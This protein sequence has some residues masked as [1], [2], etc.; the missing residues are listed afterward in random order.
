MQ[1]KYS[2][3]KYQSRVL[4]E[5]NA[6][7]DDNHLHIVAAPGS[8]KTILGLEVVKRL[9]KPTLILAPTITIRNQWIDRLTSFF[10]NFSNNKKPDW[11]SSDI[12]HP[13]IFIVTTYQALHSALNHTNK[14]SDHESNQKKHIEVK[15]SHKSS[16]RTYDS[17]ILTILKNLSINT[18]VLDE[19]HHLRT[20]WWKS[21]K[22]LIRKL[23]HPRTIALTAT[24]PYDVPP[25]EF[26]RYENLCGPIDS[27]ISVPELVL[28]K[29][30]CPHQDYIYFCTPS[31]DERL[32]I[33]SFRDSIKEFSNNLLRNKD[34]ISLI[35]GQKWIQNTENYIDEI[36]TDPAFFSSTIIFLKEAGYTVPNTILEVLGT[37][38]KQIPYFSLEWLEIFLNGCLYSHF[39][40]FPKEN[41]LLNEVKRNLKSIG[42]IYR[43]KIHLRSPRKIVKLL[44]TSKEKL[45]VIQKIVTQENRNM[46]HR[47]RL[48]ILTDYIKKDEF[49]HSSENNPPL[50][51]LGVVPIFEQIR[52]ENSLGIKI[53]VLCGTLVII[54]LSSLSSF[55]SIMDKMGIDSH[56]FN[57]VEL[58][59]DKNYLEVKLVGSFRK[60]IVSIITELFSKGDIEVLVGTASL[61][62][63]GWDAP[64]INTL[65]LASSVGSY[66]LS[67]QMRGRA[68]RTLP[69]DPDK[70]AN[71]WHIVC[72]EEQEKYGGSDYETLSRRFKSFV[73]VSF[74]EPVIENGIGRMALGEPP[75]TKNKINELNTF[76]VERSHER[77][78]LQSLWD[79]A[80]SKGTDGHLVEQL[81]VPSGFLPRNFVFRRTIE[82]LFIQSIFVGLLIA[83]YT[84]R[85]ET[86]LLRS[87]ELARGLLYFFNNDFMLFL[88]IFLLI[89]FIV[90]TF[91][92]LPYT[93]KSVVLLFKHGS[94]T[95]S[96]EQV[97]K[98]L[99]NSLINV[100]VIQTPK[101]K[102]KIV[103]EKKMGEIYCHLK[104]A[105]YYEKELFLKSL[106]ELLD[107]IEN[108]R[109]LI[110][111][112]TFLLRYFRPT[113]FFAVPQLIGTKKEF[114]KFF[115]D[116]WTKNVGSVELIY[117]RTIKGRKILLHARSHSLSSKFQT[118]SDRKSI[119]K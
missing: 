118:K 109:Y 83:I 99:L 4:D 40:Y 53:G 28:E 24:P 55:Q 42:A 91:V 64:T 7:L 48:V 2:W 98:V 17:T 82:A 66:M 31:D 103:V 73:G 50:K 107:P 34:F 23:N 119:W 68:I 25:N 86:Q 67:N 105:S 14:D 115:Q 92:A 16:S 44:M 36:L 102:I 60:I 5:L 26:K 30:L 3:R 88:L 46:V 76:M 33:K 11:I 57:L 37:N 74:I 43:G 78:K 20:E 65:I 8:G 62:G 51:S 63:E 87:D 80:L 38:N 108:P 117:T 45:K 113:D 70:T 79:D 93:I 96:M 72:V 52:R 59:H 95:S 56:N 71:I 112:K 94:L 89:P 104:H 69:N 41:P 6:H 116:Q 15:K 110:R 61:L 39:D 12:Y 32:L 18:V 49:P 29:D 90:G 27:I 22:L 85:F 21:L 10:M 9:N 106:Q 81:E 111:R 13:T 97:A 58:K 54:P 1:F 47:L 19:A 84:L 101:S 75:F 35:E 100:E 77:N 114:A